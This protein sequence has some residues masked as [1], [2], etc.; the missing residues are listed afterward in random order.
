MNAYTIAAESITKRFDSSYLFKGLSFELNTGS[1][2]SITGPNGSGKSTLLEILAFIR[3]PTSGTV[4]ISREERPLNAEDIHLNA[5][6][7]SPKVNPYG[8]LSAK[9]NI[10]FILKNN[11]RSGP[12][13]PGNDNV[14]DLLQ[15]YGLYSHRFKP[16]KNF[17]TGM[18]QRL[19]LIMAIINDPPVLFLDEPGANLDRE[20]KDVIYSYIESAKKNKIIIIATNEE[21]E[22]QLCDRVIKIA[23]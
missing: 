21:Q 9:E 22:I 11:T 8:S 20:G 3:R 16:V 4:T 23:Q 6:F 1:S 2:C 13:T 17:S 18:R 15:K 10:E 19:K 12:S 5:G 7:S 14:T